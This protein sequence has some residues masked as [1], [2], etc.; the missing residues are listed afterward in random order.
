MT[1]GI[2]PAWT[3]EKRLLINAQSEAV[4]EKGSF[5]ESFNRHRCLVPADGFYEWTA[6]GKRPHLFT[7][8]N[9]DVLLG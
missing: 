1:W 6:I 2:I 9:D 5:K 8:N 3:R 7:L 4:R